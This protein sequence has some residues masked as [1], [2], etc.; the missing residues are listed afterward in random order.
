[1]HLN[2]IQTRLQYRFD[3]FVLNVGSLKSL[4]IGVQYEDMLF[5]LTDGINLVNYD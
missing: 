5:L 2:V 1:M 3:S 4:V